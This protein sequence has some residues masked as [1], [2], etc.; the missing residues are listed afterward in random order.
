MNFTRAKRLAP[1]VILLLLGGCATSPSADPKV[2]ETPVEGDMVTV[3]VTN[4]TPTQLSLWVQYDTFPPSRLPQLR[5]H[6]RVTLTFAWRDARGVRLLARDASRGGGR[7]GSNEVF[8]RPGDRLL[9][10]IEGGTMALQ[11]I[12]DR[13]R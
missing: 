3:H 11:H 2:G 7:R 4:W 1:Y 6:E 12:Q 13:R 5:G 8:V 10:S 9:L